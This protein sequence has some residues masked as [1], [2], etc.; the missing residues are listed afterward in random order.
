MEQNKEN[1]KLTL[2]NERIIKLHHWDRM[3]EISF[4]VLVI[5]EFI[6]ILSNSDGPMSDL[7]SSL[8]GIVVSFQIG[9]WILREQTTERKRNIDR[10]GK[11]TKLYY[12][13]EALWLILV[14]TPFILTPPDFSKLI[15]YIF[16][17]A[18]IASWLGMIAILFFREFTTKNK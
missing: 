16:I 14:I 1:P 10:K 9:I 2:L 13:L 7:L 8:V 6:L 5:A 11:E 4:Y 18:Y 17:I 12:Y 15:D 3:F